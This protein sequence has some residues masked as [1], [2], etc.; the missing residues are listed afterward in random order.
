M[1][2]KKITAKSQPVKLQFPALSMFCE[3]NQMAWM[4]NNYNKLPPENIKPSTTGNLTEFFEFASAMCF[5][6]FTCLSTNLILYV[7]A[8]CIYLQVAQSEKAKTSDG[9]RQSLFIGSDTV[10]LQ[11]GRI[12]EKPVSADDALSMLKK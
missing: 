2:R 1:A 9:Y 12:F 5:L 6:I 10:V 7:A 4:A 3:A 8:F 11:G